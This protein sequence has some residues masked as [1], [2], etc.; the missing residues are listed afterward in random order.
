M[1]AMGSYFLPAIFEKVPDHEK[2][3]SNEQPQHSTT[4]RHQGAQGVGQLLS[5]CDD[6]ET[7]KYYLH[8]GHIWNVHVERITNKLESMC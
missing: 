5:L 7:V 1:F 6:T 8:L 2:V 4:V 3:E